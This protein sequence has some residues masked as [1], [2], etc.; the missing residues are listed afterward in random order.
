MKKTFFSILFLSL[1]I[2]S[3]GQ[4]IQTDRPSA[5]TENSSTVY[6][7]AFQVEYGITGSFI[8]DTIDNI[9]IP[10]SLYRFGLT[11]KIEIRISNDL[12]FSNDFK[13]ITIAP[14]QFGGKFQLIKKDDFKLAFL[15]MLAINNLKAEDKSQFFQ[16]ISTK[17]I[18]SNKLNE[19]FNLSYTL[20]HNINPVKVNNDLNYSLLLSYGIS[21]K[22]TSF[23]EFYGFMNYMNEIDNYSSLDLGLAYLI[24]DKLQLDIY[25][26]SSL[27]SNEY[28]GALGI[29]YLFSK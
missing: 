1:I 20:G 23:I 10:N 5:Q 29:S 13:E 16:N 18:G 21:N 8:E 14:L 6:K 27:S 17:I 7:N 12:T 26:G 4:T 19:K 2:G 24:N 25:L 15:S 9:A 22:I 28:F 3:F 11:E